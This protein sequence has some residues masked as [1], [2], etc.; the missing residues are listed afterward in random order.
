VEI[1]AVEDTD[2]IVAWSASDW[3]TLSGKIVFSSADSEA[4]LKHVWFTHAYCTGY[5]VEFNST[6]TTEQASLCV[7]FT[8]SPED[9]G[10]ETGG[11]EAWLAPPPREY[12]APKPIAVAPVAPAAILTTPPVVSAAVLAGPKPP[13]NTPEGIAWRW[14]QYETKMAGDPKIWPYQR[15]IKQTLTNHQNCELG[16]SREDEYQVTMGG[17]GKTLKTVYT[18]RQVDIFIEDDDYCGQLKTGKLNL[19]SQEKIDL[20]RDEWLIKQRMTVEYILEKGGSKP[21]L[22]ELSRIGASVKIGAVV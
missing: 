3:K 2:D 19:G 5:K 7:R 9:C 12:V 4:A 6:G 16:L 18:M 17:V 14:A 8:I 21:L 13:K 22:N 1:Q 15:W 10:V 11:G 20:K